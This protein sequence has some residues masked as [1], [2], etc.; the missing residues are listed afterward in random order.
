MSNVFALA[1]ALLGPAFNAQDGGQQA[2]PTA[3]VAI[4]LT[5]RIEI[6]R[7]DALVLVKGRDEWKNGELVKSNESSTD[8]DVEYLERREQGYLCRWRYGE[9]R[10]PELGDAKATEIARKIASTMSGTHFDLLLDEDGVVTAFAE[11]EAAAKRFAEH[12]E[13]VEKTL[14][15]GSASDDKAH[16]A[17]KAALRATRASLQGPALVSTLLR[18]PNQFYALGGT[19]LEVG[20]PVE[21]ENHLSNPFGG[22]PLLA[23]A[24]LELLETMGGGARARVRW[25]QVIDR[26]GYRAWFLEWATETAERAGRAAPR[27]EEIPEIDITDETLYVLDL[28]T[29]LPESMTWTRTLVSEGV[30]RVDRVRIEPRPVEA[31]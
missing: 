3:P 25:T 24:K 26:D 1:V 31:K 23:H 2:A 15:E 27:A 29:G 4:A 5:A 30:K 21:F 14:L 19:S 28:A 16:A 9:I 7:K 22:E 6:G 11:E 20:A 13:T 10:L 17:L 12:F 8:V 18:E